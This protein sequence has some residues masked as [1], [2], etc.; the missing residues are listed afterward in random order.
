VASQRNTALLL[1]AVNR[2]TIL[3]VVAICLFVWQTEISVVL[4]D[5]VSLSGQSLADMTY[6]VEARRSYDR[7]SPYRPQSV[8]WQENGYGCVL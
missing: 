4:V 3:F 8:L 5:I 6:E 7:D 1:V 2:K